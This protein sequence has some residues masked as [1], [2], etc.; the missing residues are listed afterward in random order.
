[1]S[2]SPRTVTHPGGQRAARS[3]GYSLSPTLREDAMNTR[4]IATLALVIAV[5]LLLFLVI[6]PRL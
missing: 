3:R 5:L 6:L 1:M 4:S 2:G